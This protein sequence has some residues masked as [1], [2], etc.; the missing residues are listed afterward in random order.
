SPRV[1]NTLSNVS[2]Q[3]SVSM[4]N[5]EK[6]QKEEFDKIFKE[7]EQLGTSQMSWKKR[8]EIETQKM[9]ALGSKPKKG[10]KMPI[11]VGRNIK[12]KRD[13]LEE[14]KLQDVCMIVTRFFSFEPTQ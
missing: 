5:E 1:S 7:V 2:S 11:A 4:D 3:R 14:K 6:L 9:I 12:R 13:R 8:K 10:Q